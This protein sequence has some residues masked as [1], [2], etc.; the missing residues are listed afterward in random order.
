M[1]YYDNFDK[2]IES[3][4]EWSGSNWRGRVYKDDLIQY[5]KELN[6]EVKSNDDKS[7]LYQKIRA[8]KSNYKIYLKFRDK[9]LGVPAHWYEE[10]FGITKTQR[11][12]MIEKDFIKIRYF[13]HT[14]V[15]TNTYADV[16]YADAYQFFNKMTQEKI[17]LWR[18]ENIRGFKK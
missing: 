5:C 8:N 10:K 11:K 9:A 12:K 15:F 3:E 14:K 6:I 7:T 17:D 13:V 2:L 16:A 1:I 4:C 18:E